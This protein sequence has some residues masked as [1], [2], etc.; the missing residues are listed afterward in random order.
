[1]HIAET[2]KRSN[3]IHSAAPNRSG[4]AWAQIFH[5]CVVTMS[6]LSGFGFILG[7]SGTH[8]MLPSVAYTGIRKAEFQEGEEILDRQKG[9]SS[10]RQK[11]APGRVRN[12][13]GLAADGFS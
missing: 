1:M 11:L 12:G 3:A 4:M 6:C 8:R 7:S 10:S 2:P 9:I 13:S 5:R